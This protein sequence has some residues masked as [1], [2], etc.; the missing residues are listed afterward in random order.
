[1]IVTMSS[2]PHILLVEDERSIREPLVRYLQQ[3]HFRVS[4]A[5]EAGHARQLLSAGSFDLAILD[6]MMPGEDGLSLA[7]FIRATGSL[8]VIMLTAKSDDVDRI[9]GLEIGADDY[10]GKPFNP[11]ELVARIKSVLRRTQSHRV[12]DEPADNAGGYRFGP[13]FLDVRGRALSRGE[14]RQ[15]LTEGEFQLLEAMLARAGRILTRDQL[16]DLTKQRD[17]E[18]FDRSIDNMVLR[19]RKRIEDDPSEPSFIRT[20]YGAGYVFAA[21]VERI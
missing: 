2:G 12:G 11:R 7:R 8:P 3:Q 9:V 6:I 4:A 21:D 18:P 15:S 20:V 19:L 14:D 5:S 16:L 1:M 17:R 13:W 10:L